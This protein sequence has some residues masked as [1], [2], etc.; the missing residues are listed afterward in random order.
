MKKDVTIIGSNIVAKGRINSKNDVKIS[1]R[2]EGDIVTLGDVFVE[3]TGVV[4]SNAKAKNITVA[5]S[6]EGEVTASNSINVMETG[7]VKGKMTS[8]NI[9]IDKGASTTGKISINDRN[10]KEN[11]NQS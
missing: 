4:K 5:G 1:G 9:K 2:F 8:A 10:E 7:T 6:L 3:I 11:K